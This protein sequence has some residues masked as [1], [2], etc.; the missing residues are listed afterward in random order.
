MKKY[1]LI[2]LLFLVPFYSQADDY[3]CGYIP[4]PDSQFYNLFMQEIIND[5]AYY[6]FLRTS[7]PFYQSSL[8]DGKNE[9]IQ[10]WQAFL[11]LSYQQTHYLVFKASR[12]AIENLLH[13][14]PITDQQLAFA[15]A[16]F[17]KKHKQALLYLAYA[18]YLA[19]YMQITSDS[20][21]HN[22][23]G[24]KKHN[25]SELNYNK[26]IDVLTRSWH[27]ETSKELKLR[28]GYQLVRFAHY[29]RK[30]QTAINYF[31]KYV[32]SLHYKPIM[33]YY[34]L[35]QK[36]GAE[37]GL[38]L[39]AQANADFFTF[40][41]HTQNRKESAY[42]SLRITNGFDLHQLL[43]KVKTQKAKNDVYLLLG[44]NDFNNPLASFRE[45]IK[46]SPN[47][48]QAKVLM[49]RAINQLERKYFPLTYYCP[50]NEENCFTDLKNRELPIIPFNIDDQIRSFY[51]QAL[52]ASLQQT[53][54]PAVTDKAFWNLTTAY[55]YF[56][57]RKYTQAQQFL[58]DITSSNKKY[59][60]QKKQLEL[61]IAIISHDKIDR[62]FEKTLMTKYGKYLKAYTVSNHFYG[63]KNTP[64]SFIIDILAN[65]Y[66]LQGDYGKA[67]LLQNHLDALEYGRGIAILKDIIKLYHKPQKDA[68]E[69]YVLNNIPPHIYNYRKQEYTK[70]PHFNFDQYVTQMLGTY[71]LAKGNFKQ[72][73]AEFKKVND[74]YQQLRYHTVYR[75]G[76]VKQEVEQ[77]AP[78]QFNGYSHIPRAV[79][80]SNRMVCF[81]CNDE[82][83][84][85]TPYI[86]AF[87]FLKSQMNKRELTEALI[88]LQQIVQQQGEKSAKAAYLIANFFFNTTTLGYY[89]Q[90]L[91]FD[92]TNSNGPKFH[93]Y[94]WVSVDE[95]N[96]VLYYKNYADNT[97]LINNFQLP[98]NYLEK[99][100]TLTQDKELKARLLFTAAKCEQGIFY[101]KGISE[102]NRQNKDENYF[103]DD[104]QDKVRAFKVAHYRPYFKRLKEQYSQTHYYSQ[105][106]T[107]CK[108]FDYY[109][110]HY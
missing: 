21:Y 81:N 29:N 54:N 48:I 15:T 59:L 87:P 27:A 7:Q 35:D 34:A 25:V 96:H 91:T 51:Q 10:E 94:W 74:T 40:F 42:K 95:H 45:I 63:N 97:M 1:F 17:V 100:L 3:F 99:G 71:Y 110:T 108:Y 4:A 66:L 78:H 30:Y 39:N 5:P 16:S 69:K 76:K 58:A 38:G 37:R 61:L 47:A 65:R 82:E 26:V 98:L 14:K 86:T 57:Q 28:Y 32:A 107:N 60:Q 6:P 22:Y 18:K 20:R 90:I 33:Y 103:S 36:A 55:L 88:K 41:M 46:N 64:A 50:Y 23:W 31:K 9:N 73:L 67:F 85:E 93:N 83:V 84:M 77:Y 102:F 52:L 106:K 13:H 56:M 75:S 11:G 101:Q 104:Y 19:P 79:F 89:R 92:I 80:G 70:V 49:A 44:F 8:P 105:L 109:T 68:F 43:Q 62:A 53:Q 12:K 72:A 24:K 2:F